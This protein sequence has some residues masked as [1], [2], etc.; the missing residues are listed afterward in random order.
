VRQLYPQARIT[1]LTKSYVRP[2]IDPCPWCDRVIETRP[3][4]RKT[5]TKADHRDRA[6]RG[7]LKLAERLRRRRFDLAVLLPNSFR[8]A[9]LARLA[10]IP[11]RVGYDRDG[12][13]FLLT[14]RLLAMRAAGK[15]VPTSTLQY[16]LGIAR[17][18]G[19]EKPDSSMQ[20][21]TR[22]E[23]DCK[24]DQ[25]LA[26]AGV[27]P[28]RPLVLLNPGANYG[29]AK[30]WYPQ[31]FAAVADQ[32]IDQR[33]ATVLVNGSPKERRI[34]DEV[35]AAAKHD[36]I[37]L[38]K[39]GSDL[40]LLKSI[41]SRCNLMVTND[42]GPRHLAAA[43]GVPVVTIFGP[44]DPRWTEIHF[45]DER[46]V[47]VDVICGPCQKKTCPLDHRCMKLIEPEMVTEEALALLDAR[48]GN[49]ENAKT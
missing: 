7:L 4:P 23:L 15:F 38:P 36:L 3:R 8:T 13:G 25:L 1:Y 31:R 47:R 41:I 2:L 39:L 26:D 16:Y 30:L 48:A 11:R 10:N 37:D 24:A 42:T 46:Q 12:R 22:P 28:S 21:F 5:G 9:L 6:S 45:D 40:S 33:G 20:L 17:Y 32:L 29:E 43:F 44:T 19:L 18:L 14:D 35:H 27:D 49:A 34:L